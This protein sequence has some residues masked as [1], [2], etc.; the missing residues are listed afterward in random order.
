MNVFTA[1]ATSARR[2]INSIISTYLIKVR[3]RLLRWCSE[4]A[5]FGRLVL[6]WAAVSLGANAL[7]EIYAGLQLPI[8]LHC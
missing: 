3:G 6:E 5:L 1:A 2:W 8:I 7:K 4:Q